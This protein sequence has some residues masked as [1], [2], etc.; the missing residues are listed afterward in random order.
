MQSE[1]SPARSAKQ[2]QTQQLLCQLVDVALVVGL[3]LTDRDD[4][5]EDFPPLDAEDDAVILTNGA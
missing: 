1:V 5:D 3:P 4:H 2:A